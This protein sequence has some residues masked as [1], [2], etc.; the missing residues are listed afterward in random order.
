M[1]NAFSR[2]KWTGLMAF[3]LMYNFV[4]LGRFNVNHL[5]D[6]IA[7]D[8]LM[9]ERQQAVISMSVFVSYALGSFVN[10]YLADRFGA[11]RIVITGG[12]MTSVFNVCIPFQQDW[13][14]VLLI[15]FLNGY[16]QSMIWVGGI[17]FLSH[18]WEEGE[19]GKGVGIANFFSGMSHATAYAIPILLMSLWPSMGWRMNF[20][21]PIG[22]LLIFV[23]LFGIFAVE[24]PERVG[25]EPYSVENQRH[26]E[27]EAV[28][29]DIAAAKKPPWKFFFS[30]GR[31]WW[32]CAVAMLC[33]ICRYGLLDWI[34]LYYDE[35]GQGDL[36]SDSFSNLTLPIGM[37]FGTLI[38][39]WVAGTK[40]V[41]NKGVIVTAMAAIC[42]TLIIVFPMLANIQS[43]LV[44][45]F[46]TGFTLYGINGILWVHA[47]DQGCRVFSG[48]AAGIFNGFAY[49]GACLER[50][51]FPE[52]LGWFGS[53]LSVFVVMEGLCIGMVL[54]GMVVSKKN[55]IVEPEVRE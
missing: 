37:A 47:I 7:E 27:R 42:G 53:S 39:T 32:W 33:S 1:S 44:G 16:F 6:F 51:V 23:L 20:I 46:F 5:M 22:I 35:E 17:S 9:T 12:I 34:P 4:Y 28:L 43:V 52:I 29:T 30:Q 40:L 54:C 11:K 21:V 15:W 19:R 2:Y 14:S 48:S 26:R 31:F 25:L 36:L 38:I 45:I 13:T 3:S 24:K 18:W 10:G 50:Y 41:N 8:L 55:T 49:L